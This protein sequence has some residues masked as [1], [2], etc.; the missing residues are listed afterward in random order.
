MRRRELI[1]A[2]GGAAVWPRAAAQ[3]Q[4]STSR[5]VGVITLNSP[6]TLQK[7]LMPI[8]RRLAEQGYVEGRNLVFEYRWAY[9]QEDR[10]AALSE[11]LVQ[12]RVDAI[13][14]LAGPMIAAAKAATTSI[15]I[16]FLRGLIPSQVDLSQA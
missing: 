2:I 12:R 14:A 8:R 7:N 1:V 4:A 15:P 9:G 3:G 10:L 13:V 16:V 11:D 6:D 5:I